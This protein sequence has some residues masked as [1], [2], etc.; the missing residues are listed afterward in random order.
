MNVA[1]SMK[2]VKS[3]VQH[4]T[5]TVREVRGLTVAKPAHARAHVGCNARPGTSRTSRTR[6]PGETARPAWNGGMKT[7]VQGTPRHGDAK[8]PSAQA[9]QAMQAECINMQTRASKRPVA[10]RGDSPEVQ[11]LS[12]FLGMGP[13]PHR[14]FWEIYL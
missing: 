4:C 5:P 7:H 12:R 11:H 9:T 13:E 2:S 1:R 8:G 10:H 14:C 6:H 3:V